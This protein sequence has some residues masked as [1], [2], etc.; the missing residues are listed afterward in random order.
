[1]KLHVVCRGM[2][3]LHTQTLSMATTTWGCVPSAQNQDHLNHSVQ[4]WSHSCPTVEHQTL[5]VLLSQLNY[6]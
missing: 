2:P 3:L 5:V 6:S 1:M 4:S